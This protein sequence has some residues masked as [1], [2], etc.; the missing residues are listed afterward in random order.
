MTDAAMDPISAIA[1]L[2]AGRAAASQRWSHLMFLHWRVD[3]ALVAPLLPA[4]LVPDEFD[5]T[6]WVGLIPFVLDRATVFGSPPIP[7]F[8][9]FVEVN[10]RLY[11]VDEQGHRGVVFVSLEASRLAAV[12]AARALFSIPYMWS[13]TR[14]EVSSGPGSTGQGSAG[15][16]FHYTSR[17]HLTG[18]AHTDIVVRPTNRPVVGDLL[19][20]FL[21]ARWALFTRTRGRTVHLRNHHEPWALYEA[22][23]LRLDDTL[24]AVAGFPGLAER[25]PDSVLYAP[26]VTTWF[27]SAG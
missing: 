9:T 24:L 7:Y 4:G 22:E 21:T 15:P 27:G 13:R 25:P 17:R 19:A 12:L 10:V 20:D 14:L 23:L 3:A 8:G 1:P 26:G 11:A 5:G 2:L 18:S 16:E 6:S